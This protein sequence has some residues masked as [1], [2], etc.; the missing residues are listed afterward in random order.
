MVG[1]LTRSLLAGWAAATASVVVGAGLAAAQSI[2]SQPLPPLPAPKAQP[3]APVQ[4]KAPPTAAAP[5]GGASGQADAAPRSSGD[6]ALARRVEQLEEQLVDMQVVIGTLESLAKSGGASAGA[7]APSLRGQGG[8]TP[9]EQGRLDALE[10]QVRALTAQIEQLLAQQSGV[11]GRRSEIAPPPAV[12]PRSQPDPRVRQGFAQQAPAVVPGFGETTVTAADDAIGQ[13]L[14]GNAGMGGSAAEGGSSPDT[15]YKTSSSYLVQ[16]NYGQAEAG[17]TEFLKRYPNDPMA[18]SAQY[19]L[20]EIYF[21]QGQFKEAASAFLKASKSY[22]RSMKAP[23]SLLMLAMSLDR[24]GQ[25]EAACQSFSELNTR[26]P[27][28]PANLRDRAASGRQRAGC[29]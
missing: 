17:F 3:A 26:F 20:G 22:P 4:Q 13:L 15:L 11:P 2:Q 21:T 29:S 14:S 28:L 5:K 7:S 19:W 1:L 24:L 10:T 23:D 27:N 18:G 12:D 8:L 6:S 9:G 25:R 16:Q